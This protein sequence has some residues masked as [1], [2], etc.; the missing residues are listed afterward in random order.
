[1][2]TARL[3]VSDPALAQAITAV[4][5][6][7][8]PETFCVFTYE[9]K[10]KIVLK[11]TGSGDCYKAVDEFD[12]AAVSYALLRVTGTRDQESKTVK[13][14]FLV[15]VGPSVGGM[16]RGRVGGHKGDVKELMGQSHVDIQSDDKADMTEEAITT[17]LKKASGANYDL[18]SNAGGAYQSNAGDIR[19]KAAANYKTLEKESNIGPV[20][21]EKYAKPKDYVSPMDL[22]GRPMVAPPTAAKKNTVVRDEAAVAKNPKDEPDYI[23]REKAAAYAA[24]S[25]GTSV[26]DGKAAAEAKAA[27]EAKA[28]AQAA[29]EA[30]AAQAAAEAEAAKEAEA[31]AAAAQAEA[32]AELAA[33]K[34]AEE[35]ALAKAAEAEAA[36]AAQVP[37]VPEKTP[38]AE[39]D[40]PSKEVP[41]KLA[42]EEDDAPSKEVPEVPE[43]TPPLDDSLD[44]P[45][46]TPVEEPVE[47]A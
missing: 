45:A 28:A 21:F 13:F 1:M 34:A 19:A 24:R 8:T 2:N 33:A 30:K 37:D 15:Y 27:E 10:S 29:E 43:K 42:C 32:E 12:E 17:K 44:A 6:D 26:D 20:V 14:V 38:P 36:A 39:D 4:R 40:A 9:G 18:G 23:A 22:G 41:E 3:D 7:T 25:T 11:G 31:A 35:E 46:K 47:V 16:A 5:S